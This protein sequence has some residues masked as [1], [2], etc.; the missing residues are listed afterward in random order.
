MLRLPGASLAVA[1]LM[2]PGMVAAELGLAVCAETGLLP[3][4]TD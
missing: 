3:W 2:A 1:A 4:E